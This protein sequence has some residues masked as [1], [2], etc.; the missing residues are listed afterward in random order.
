MSTLI[1]ATMACP[2]G[3]SRAQSFFT[4][5]TARFLTPS[6]RDSAGAEH[7]RW[8]VLYSPYGNP[9]ITGDGSNFPDLAAPNGVRGLASALGFTP[10][11]NADPA[12]PIAYWHAANPAIRQT[13]TSSA[14]IVGAGGSGNIYSFAAV[15]GYEVADNAPAPLG[16]V[17]LQW[18]TDGQLLDFATLRLVAGSN[19]YA[20]TNFITEYKA[21]TSG[22]GGVTNRAAAQWD[23]TDLGIVSY[24]I[25]FQSES[26]STSF[27][28]ALLDTAPAYAEA[29]PGDRA[30]NASSG[31]WSDAAN[32]SSGSLPPTG[33]NVIVASGASLSVDGGVREIGE[34]RLSAPGAFT[35]APGG[36]TLKLNTGL[37]ATPDAP[38]SYVID[39]P[40]TMGA[41]NLHFLNA[42]ARVVCNGAI[43]G[44]VGFYLAGAGTLELNAANTFTGAITVDPDA[45]L[46][47]SGSIAARAT[48]Q[49]RHAPA[50]T[51]THGGP[52]AYAA[53][54]HLSWKLGTNTTAAGAH[55]RVVAAGVTVAAGALL[56]LQFDAPGGAVDFRDPFWW[57]SR[58]WPVLT[59]TALSG[60]FAL[61]AVSNDAAGNVAGNHGA[62]A[63][64]HAPTGVT[65]H[66][67]PHAA[68][69]VWR[70]VNF[71][72]DWNNAAIA[73]E[74]VDIENDGQRNVV[75]YALGGTSAAF[76]AAPRASRE[77]N[78]LTIHFTRNP[79]ATDATI[80]VLAAGAVTGPWT[81]LAESALGAPTTVTLGGVNVSEA[82][83][84]LLRVVEVRDLF[85]VSDAAHPRRFLQ[86]QVQR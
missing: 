58:S 51:F 18:Q 5:P 47:G 28:E 39:A 32:W 1:V 44:A 70:R 75:E 46:G 52:L 15:T 66:W 12:D 43:D 59:S 37:A 61:G 63:L 3:A 60:A 6:W 35:V 83:A 73:G 13:A 45:T 34:F 65:L 86:V 27:Q 49:G 50:G 82:V 22:F 54:A 57:S 17:V 77:G 41:Y 56:D 21:G 84:G 71:G 85:L 31:A 30:W 36:G 16:T 26:S 55:D 4:T 33:G 40:L 38:A 23:L 11:A 25:R 10:P 79:A 80:R 8:D 9:G 64:T 20:P 42:N 14:F 7:S 53:T 2:A 68:W 72:S 19:E 48:V 69:E 24:A 76:D 29:V 67:T 78:R 81:V 62:F 74:L